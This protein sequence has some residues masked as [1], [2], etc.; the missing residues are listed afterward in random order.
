MKYISYSI[1]GVAGYGFGVS[2]VSYGA[3]DRAGPNSMGLTSL[4]LEVGIF[5]EFSM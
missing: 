1:M 4:G 5:C 3:Q 2:F